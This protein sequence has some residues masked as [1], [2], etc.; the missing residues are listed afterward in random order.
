V[1]SAIGSVFLHD[2]DISIRVTK[3]NIILFINGSDLTPIN[4]FKDNNL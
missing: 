3:M 1:A 4:N 2:P